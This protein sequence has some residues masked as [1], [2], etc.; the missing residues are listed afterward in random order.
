LIAGRLGLIA[1]GGGL[2]FTLAGSCEAAGRA[3]FVVRLRGFADPELARFP[4][5]EIGIAEL[6]GIMGALREAGCASVCMAG[7]VAR[8]DFAAL[9]PDLRGLRA[10]PGAIAA[11]GKGDDALLRFL[12]GEFE[13]EGFAVEGAHEV[14]A[15]LTLPLG[16]L[17]RVRPDPAQQADI[18]RAITVARA[19]GALDV[20]QGAVVS[21]NLVLA[22]EAQEGTDAMLARVATLPQA[23][24]GEPGQRRGV[25]AKALKPTQESRIDMPVIG[26]R[27]VEGAAGAGLAGVAGEASRVLLLDREAVIEAAD[28]LG[29]FVFGVEGP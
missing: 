8:P 24:R 1:G 11:A 20:G 21:A 6:G 14:A 25:L 2:P 23:L 7:A 27:T 22:V 17:G 10:L 29:L 15:A 3:V 12:L 9:K 18:S 5:A 28:R 4:G 19:L 13:R 26:P 16:P